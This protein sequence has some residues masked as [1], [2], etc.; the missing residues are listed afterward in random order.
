M[1][2][3]VGQ[4]KGEVRELS[5]LVI[6]S[7]IL[8]WYRV[9]PYTQ[10]DLESANEEHKPINHTESRL[11]GLAFQSAQTQHKLFTLS[12]PTFMLR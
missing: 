9:S 10:A 11:K 2:H 1:Q 3:A 5:H 4:H 6:D 12:L 8:L 7:F